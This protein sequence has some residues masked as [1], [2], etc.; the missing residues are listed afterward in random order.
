MNGLLLL[1]LVAPMAP[2]MR[3]VTDSTTTIVDPIVRRP[4]PPPPPPIKDPPIRTAIQNTP[5]PVIHQPTHVVDPPP[6]ALDDPQP[7]DTVA[8]QPTSET[9]VA[10][11]GNIAPA[12]DGTPLAGA[13]LE[14]ASNP[15]PSYPSS[16]LRANEQGTVMLEVLVDVDG[17]PIEVRIARSSGYRAL[18]LAARRQVLANW[19][20]RPAMRNGQPVQA[21][22]MVPV[23]F[24]LD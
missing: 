7:G 20:F 24:H 10:D 14:Y 12:D 16:S 9:L 15:A 21:I 18:D 1:L 11:N 2:V 17:K 4:P 19:M 3:A 23:E 13:H 8:Q 22:G 6:L 5:T